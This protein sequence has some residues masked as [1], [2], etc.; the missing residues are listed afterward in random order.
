MATYFC[1]RKGDIC[2]EDSEIS[3]KKGDPVIIDT[4]LRYLP[5]HRYRNRIDFILFDMNIIWPNYQACF[6]KPPV[7]AEEFER[8]GMTDAVRELFDTVHTDF[9]HQK[10][11]SCQIVTQGLRCAFFCQKAVGNHFTQ[12]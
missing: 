8:Y 7:T 10:S 1:D 12:K 11:Q 2:I 3:A 6:F 9:P 4:A 5:S